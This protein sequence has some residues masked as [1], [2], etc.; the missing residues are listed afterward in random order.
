MSAIAPDKLEIHPAILKRLERIKTASKPDALELK[1]GAIAFAEAQVDTG[2]AS[3]DYL[4]EVKDRTYALA[5]ERIE[6]LDR[7]PTALISFFTLLASTPNLIFALL[8]LIFQEGYNWGFDA[9]FSLGS[10]AV[11][12]VGVFW[13]IGFRNCWFEVKKR[14]WR[15]IVGFS[16]YILV[17]AWLASILVNDHGE[18]ESCSQDPPCTLLQGEIY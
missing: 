6:Y 4:E 5:Y 15:W 8:R 10:V 7:V 12:V 2:T 14:K 1:G 9:Y 18:W 16:V 17:T 11:G 3:V 13:S